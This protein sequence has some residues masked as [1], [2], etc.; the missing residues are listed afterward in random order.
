VKVPLSDCDDR[1]RF[2]AMTPE[3]RLEIFIQLCDLTDSI[4]N[5]RPDAERLRAP[6]P[7]SPESEALWKRLMDAKRG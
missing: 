1:E 6:V 4:V 7:R 5:G 3:E 2:A